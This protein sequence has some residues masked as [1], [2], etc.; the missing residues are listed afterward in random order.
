VNVDVYPNPCNHS[1]T[2]TID[3]E[4]MENGSFK[5][6]DSIGCLVRM[7]NMN[8]NNIYFEKK[9]LNAGVYFFI[10]ESDGKLISSGKLIIL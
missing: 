5:L 7:E 10:I 2:I 4:N 1:T 9:D 3:G 6:Y 8:R